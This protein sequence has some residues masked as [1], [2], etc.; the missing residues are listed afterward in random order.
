[1][2]QAVEGKV[3]PQCSPRLLAAICPVTKSIAGLAELA[4]LILRLLQMMRT[5][6]SSGEEPQEANSTTLCP[7]QP[8]LV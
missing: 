6:D 1:M 7:C 5:E 2:V 8:V 3:Q 4:V